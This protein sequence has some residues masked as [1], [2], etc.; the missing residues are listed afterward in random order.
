M[1]S[2]AITPIVLICVAVVMVLVN[3]L[4][5]YGFGLAEIM[6]GCVVL[7]SLV[8]IHL[9]LNRTNIKNN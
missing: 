8:A 6:L 7:G 1:K 5:L 3:L 4:R 2:R 9:L